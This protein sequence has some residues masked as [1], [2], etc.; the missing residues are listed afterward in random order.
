MTDPPEMNNGNLSPSRLVEFQVNHTDSLIGYGAA[1]QTSAGSGSPHPWTRKPPA[2]IPDMML[3][4][5]WLPRTTPINSE[6][7]HYIR[8]AT[9]QFDIYRDRKI[10]QLHDGTP[11]HQM[12]L[13]PTKHVQA[14]PRTARPW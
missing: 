8:I 3:R 14:A 9:R 12:Y 2:R 10:G 6:A 1:G 4:H 5:R 11:G 13:C 7:D